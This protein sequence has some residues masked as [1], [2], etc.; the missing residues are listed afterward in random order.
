MCI[1]TFSE[2]Y[3]ITNCSHSLR[4]LLGKAPEGE[5]FMRWLGKRQRNPF[6][7]WVQDEWDR[8]V[9]GASEPFV[10]TPFQEFLR[11]VPAH[12]KKSG[13]MPEGRRHP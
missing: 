4:R 1:D 13:Q 7:G 5:P 6:I 9:D 3:T 2:G 10:A 11:M 12:L 8:L